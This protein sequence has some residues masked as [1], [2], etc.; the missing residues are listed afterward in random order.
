MSEYGYDYGR[1]RP[2]GSEIGND[3]EKPLS[4][5][6]QIDS[7]SVSMP[8]ISEQGTQTVTE[9]DFSTE[10]LSALQD[11]DTSDSSL[12]GFNSFD[13]SDEKL[14]SEGMIA[15]QDENES[16]QSSSKPDSLTTVN[17]GLISSERISPDNAIKQSENLDVQFQSDPPGGSFRNE[18]M[19][20]NADLT[21]QDNESPKNY[22]S[23]DKLEDSPD[24][25]KRQNVE[26]L[27]GEK[28]SKLN[29]RTSPDIQFSD[30]ELEKQR[31]TEDEVK[32][33]IN[34]MAVDTDGRSTHNIEPNSQ[35]NT[36]EMSGELNLFREQNSLV[37]N[38]DTSTLPVPVN[39]QK[40]NRNEIVLENGDQVITTG[41]VQAFK[42]LNHQQGEVEGFEGTCG[43]CS[44]QC[45]SNQFGLINEN[46]EKISEKDVVN[47]A[48]NEHPP[49]C[50]IE[51]TSENNGG[52]SQEGQ[53]ILLEKLGIPAHIESGKSMDQLA[54][55]VEQAKGV[56]VGLEATELW[57]DNPHKGIN[58]LP[59]PNH[60]V[61]VID[62]ARDPETN[63][64]KGFFIN[65]S[66]NNYDNIGSGRFV[67]VGEMQFCWQN[68]GGRYVVTNHSFLNRGANKWV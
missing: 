3:V 59:R 50:V 67:S 14:S 10:G 40:N 61:T 20:T 15:I 47:I 49:L 54:E 52:T 11:S 28:D 13:S 66:G 35:Q 6:E 19:K 12:A 44:V 29:S 22:S 46:G 68:H 27:L 9:Q 48:R 58:L 62:T 21:Q 64:L 51:S 7:P 16:P 5:S 8:E 26:G 38:S 37:P 55:E 57:G 24:L 41:G 42:D 53:R 34:P 18:E 1:K 60:A 31:P 2:A 23:S 17:S 33:V 43:L 32:P 63:K 39:D 4:K 56:I 65:D 45:V 25:I 36:S 30:P